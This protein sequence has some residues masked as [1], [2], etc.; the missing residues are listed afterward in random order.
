GIFNHLDVDADN[1]GI[2]NI[3][4]AGGVDA[5]GDGLVDDDTDTDGDGLADTYDTD[6]LGNSLPALDSDGDGIKDFLDLDADGDGIPDIIEAKG[7]DSDGDGRVDVDMTN[8]ANDADRDGFADIYD[9]DDD[10]T[11]GIDAGEANQPLVK[12]TDSGS[13]GLLDAM[14]DGEG[15]SLD[16][17]NDGLADLLDIDADNDGLPDL[18]EARGI[19]SDGDGRVDNNTDADG[20]GLADVYDADATDGPAGSGTNGTPLVRTAGTDTDGDYKADDLAIVWEHGSGADLDVDGDGYPEFIDLDADNDG[21]PDLIESLGVDANGDGRVDA[22]TDT[23]GDGLADIYDSDA[24]DGPSGTGTNG[25]PLIQTSGTDTG[26]DGYALGDGGINYVNGSSSG[27]PD[28]DGDNIPNYVDLDSD[29]DG[30]L[31]VTEAG[32]TD[33][34]RD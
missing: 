34:N 32:A 19:D 26:A 22:A 8:V 18:I 33:S 1:D 25:T 24:A 3:I 5:N 20:D 2:P 31:D 23:D 27:L 30:L 29:N 15:K 10:G 4:E 7:I 11:A 28:L 12:S 17:D 14:T 6:N 9:S 13:D 16:T 21:I